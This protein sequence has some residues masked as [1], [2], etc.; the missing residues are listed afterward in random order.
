M[1]E[2]IHNSDDPQWRITPHCLC[3]VGAARMTSTTSTTMKEEGEET[4]S[5][6]VGSWRKVP[7]QNDYKFNS[8]IDSKQGQTNISCQRRWFTFFSWKWPKHNVIKQPTAVHVFLCLDIWQKNDP[9]MQ[10]WVKWRAKIYNKKKFKKRDK[11]LKLV[12]MRP[13]ILHSIGW[14]KMQ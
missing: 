9:L 1:Q 12:T 3:W 5:D 10:G 2:I 13:K 14:H 11:M 4:T 8:A 7:T 6:T